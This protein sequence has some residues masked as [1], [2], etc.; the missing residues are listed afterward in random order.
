[1]LILAGMRLAMPAKK[2]KDFYE[3]VEDAVNTN[4]L[5]RDHVKSPTGK[6]RVLLDKK[7]TNKLGDMKLSGQRANLFLTG[8]DALVDV[9][10][11]G[12]D[13]E[14]HQSLSKVP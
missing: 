12:Y 5:R 7:D 1:M 6:W 10:Y 8:F 9:C 13:P 3:K 14:L 4:I 2:F 11:E